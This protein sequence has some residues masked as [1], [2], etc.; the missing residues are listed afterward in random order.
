MKF[1]LKLKTGHYYKVN[2][3]DNIHLMH[4]HCDKSGFGAIV[5][6][7]VI[8]NNA[9]KQIKNCIG[10]VF[11]YKGNIGAGLMT[12]EMLHCAMWYDRVVNGFNGNYGLECN[13]GEERLAYILT[14][15]VTKLNRKLWKLGVY[16]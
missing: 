2:I 8:Q 4:K 15:L 11:F 7:F 5:K 16:E 13:D 1:N 6:P 10:E 3:F 9:T 14:E 12:H